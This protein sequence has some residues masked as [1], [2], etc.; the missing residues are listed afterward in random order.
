MN[1][2]LVCSVFFCALICEFYS[3]N[4]PMDFSIHSGLVVFS[5]MLYKLLVY[6]A[7]IQDWSATAD[8]PVDQIVFSVTN[9][10]Q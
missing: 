5:P 1:E 6:A 10:Y 4:K 9:D 8:H 3:L 7:K 2:F